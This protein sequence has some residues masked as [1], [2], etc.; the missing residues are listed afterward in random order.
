MANQTS[1]L[2]SD[3]GLGAG[4]DPK[5]WVWTVTSIIM[6]GWYFVVTLTGVGVE[7]RDRA[8]NRSSGNV[9][10]LAGSITKI[11]VYERGP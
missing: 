8:I 3:N 1:L 11:L 5:L 6:H 10:G 2:T 7:E 9:A 4:F